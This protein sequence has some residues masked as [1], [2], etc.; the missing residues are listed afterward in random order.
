MG[1]GFESPCKT[2]LYDKIVVFKIQKDIK[3]KM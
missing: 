3:D 1:R 2:L